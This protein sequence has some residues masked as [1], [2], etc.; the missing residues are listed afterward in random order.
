MSYHVLR[1][2]FG[3]ASFIFFSFPIGVTMANN[4][5]LN[6]VQM[7]VN[8]PF[9]TP[10]SDEIYV[11][12]NFN[13]CNW[14]A[15]CI[16]LQKLG[17]NL[18]STS[19]P[20]NKLVEFKVTRGSWHNEAAE[21]N[22]YPRKNSSINLKQLIKGNTF[23]YDIRN[24]KDLGA[25][26]VTGNID[27]VQNF[28]SPELGNERTLHIRLPDDYNQIGNQKKYP[29]IYMHDGQNCFD[30]KTSTYGTDWSVDEVLSEMVDAGLVRDA[31][32]VGV[33]SINRGNEYN[34]ASLGQLYGKFL[35]ETVR[36]YIEQNY[37]VE[38]GPDHTFLMGSSFGSAISVS[39]AWRYPQIF[40]KVAGVAFN[41]SFF[42]NRLFQLTRELPLTTT[43]IY[44]DHGNIFGDSSYGPPTKRFLTH[45]KNIGM[46]EDQYEFHEI[47]YS[48]H[49]EADWAR[50][51]HLPLMFLLK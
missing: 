40:G 34:D 33:F 48:G 37:R 7:V 14:K 51:V 31:I 50:R 18:F 24:W 4:G 38:T 20:L 42:G 45:L 1:C 47:P 8:T 21:P 23:V 3:F 9:N 30:P 2:V 46:N 28:H 29:V 12:G 15:N 22:G 13:N 25:L 26:K 32:V 39:M 43:Q 16:P 36:P 41:G 27:R 5:H 10:D 19:L 44:L 17:K 35:V 11:T 49:T 6:Q